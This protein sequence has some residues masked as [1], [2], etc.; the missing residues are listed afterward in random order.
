MRGEKRIAVLGA[1]IMG[2][3]AA[4]FLARR[5]HAVTLF[6]AEGAP[7]SGAS[8][9]NEGKIH[10]G[11]VYAADPSLR[12]AERLLPGALAFKPLVEAL[13][14]G[15]IDPAATT[16]DDDLFLCHRRSVVSP[17]AMGDYL[18]RV[19]E[20][21]R[22]HPDARD[23]LVDLS[24][25]A[26][27]ALTRAELAAVTSSP[28]IVAGFRAPERSVSTV[29]LADR[30]LA[31]LA[32]ERRIELRLGARV[33]AVR[34][35]T[36]DDLDGRWRVLTTGGGAETFDAVVNALW[37]GRLAI[38]AEAGLAPPPAWSHRY[39]LSLFVRTK[40]P[41]AAPSGIVAV[42]PFGDIKRYG[43]RDFY[44]SWYPDGLRTES[45]ALAP[46]DPPPL[47]GAGERRLSEAMLD[48][49]TPLLPA[50]A[51]IRRKAERTRLRGGWVF[52]AGQGQLSDPAATLHRRADFG[53]TRLGAYV[54]VD[55][56]KYSSA[57]WLAQ[58]VAERLG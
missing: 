18:R 48:H 52:A 45:A 41:V 27:R 57:P 34:P 47:N 19:A 13:I 26:A 25:C 42:G 21:V 51:E 44:L 12:T 1:G 11:F 58:Q 54:S 3:S 33:A 56:G 5:G 50:V 7:F 28:E 55:T 8:R 10:L 49:L 17:Q 2:S 31:A 53:I 32:A 20:L 37:A 39:R 29:W 9:W 16:E 40:A 46:P 43:D 22:A 23:Y 4:L 36:P 15:P 30:F 24:R 6:D 14:G 38:D 35:E